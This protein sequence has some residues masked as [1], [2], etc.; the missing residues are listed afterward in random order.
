MAKKLSPR[1]RREEKRQRRVRMAIGIF[2]IGVMVL[3]TIA[4]VVVFYATP[5]G[6]GGYNFNYQIQDNQLLVQTS[7][8]TVAF[9]N[10]P[11][12]RFTLP[13]SSTDLLQNAQRV[14][15]AFDPDDED[16]SVFTEQVRFDL[17]NH[18]PVSAAR[19]HNSS[20]Y[21]SLPVVSCDDATT[22]NPIV[23][24]SN[25]SSGVA[26]T[27]NCIQFG[28]EGQE[29]LFARDSLLYSYYDLL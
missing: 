12:E 7:A 17:L 20:E 28:V 24:F 1:Q 14:V 23:M 2:T 11:D 4:F 25:Q 15:I 16:L 27:D 22:Q 18:F 13:D 26:V 6:Q 9:V 10:F 29:V 19:I 21:A 8:G 5:E 3:S